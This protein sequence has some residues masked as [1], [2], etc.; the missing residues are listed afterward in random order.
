MAAA[1]KAIALAQA[2]GEPDL[3]NKNR[4][5]LEVYRQHKAYREVAG[6]FVHTAK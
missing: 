3:L 1:Q 6:S 5:L 4:E 2:N